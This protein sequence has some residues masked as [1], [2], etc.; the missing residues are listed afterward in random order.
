[1]DEELS[2]T[3]FEIR[4]ARAEIDE[5]KRWLTPLNKSTG[6]QRS[7]SRRQD[8]RAEA[9]SGCN[10]PDPM[11]PGVV[12]DSLE[13]ATRPSTPVNTEESSYP[14]SLPTTSMAASIR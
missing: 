2:D 6:G 8:S 11:S 13:V 14:S 7:R 10:T 3:F 9:S 12:V 1:M 4:H 5:R